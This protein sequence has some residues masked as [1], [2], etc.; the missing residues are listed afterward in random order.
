M[1]LV[2]RSLWGVSFTVLSAVPCAHASG[3]DTDLFDLSLEELLQVKV[4]SA[5]KIEESLAEAPATMI[6]LS[7]DELR[8]RGYDNLTEV[9]DDLPSM[10]MVRPFGDT[11]F[12]NYM[13]GYRNTIGTPYLVLIDGVVF[14]S[15]Y[16]NITMNIATLPLSNV[17][18]IEVVYGPASS[19][20]GANAFMGVINI[21]TQRPAKGQESQLEFTQRVGSDGGVISDMSWSASQGELIAQVSARLEHS[22][23]RHRINDQ[24][25]YWLQDQHY[26]NRALWGEF[27]DHPEYVQSRFSSALD[28]Y[29]IDAR[30]NYHNWE[31][32]AQYSLL[33]SGYGTIYP[34]DKIPANSTWPLYQGSYYLRYQS[35]ITSNHLSRTLLRY[36]TDGVVNDSHDLEAWNVRNT[37]NDTLSIGG[38]DLKPGQSARMLHFQYWASDNHGWTLQQDFDSKLSEGWSLAYGGKYDYKDLQKAYQQ[39]FSGPIAASSS[40][41]L[42]QLPNP[43]QSGYIDPNNRITWRDWG[44]YV[45][46]KHR[47]SANSN[48]NFGVR[49]DENSAYGNSTN[50]RGAYNYQIQHWNF[51]LMYGEGFQEP[52]PRSLYGAWAGSGAD[53]ELAPETSETLEASAQYVKDQ[54]SHLWSWYHINNNDTVINFSGGARNAGNRDIIGVDYHMSYQFAP[55]S[56]GKMTAKAYASYYFKTDEQTFDLGS[57]QQ[58]GSEAIGDLATLKL[59]AM[60]DWRY[61]DNRGI[62][63]TA[64]HISSRDTVVS[65]P[66][67]RIP[68]YTVFDINSHWTGLWQ[69]RLDVSL[70]VLNVFNKG[71]FHPG[72]RDADAG[73]PELTPSLLAGIGFHN[74]DPLA[75]QG[76]KGWYN[77]RL[78][79]PERRVV[80]SLTVHF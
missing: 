47:L 73:A 80:A 46:S 23:L 21:I 8:A 42:D 28:S 76:S 17:Q 25:V 50:L 19:V 55:G 38:I 75:W 39:T 7:K 62:Y 66:V 60:L 53:P 49:F 43:P 79:Q 31:F 2:L 40:G 56:W 70:R 12:V 48:V 67:R 63:L 11:Y 34:A 35:E 61:R 33:D 52:T 16:F 14:N 13:R 59:W 41:Q 5:S 64:R 18:R 45:Q 44:L 72:I 3:E 71:Y 77:S 6:V 32:A 68:G 10:E 36:R 27:L 58:A 20:Y 57:Q 37:T 24:Q 78:P 51:K 1:Q 4:H 29:S 54:V 15:L 22:D 30:L 65:N 9:F 69:G 74:D 26:A